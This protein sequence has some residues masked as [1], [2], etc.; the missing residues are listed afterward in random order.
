MGWEPTGTHDG[1][2]IAL[3]LT[4]QPAPGNPIF[5]ECNTGVEKRFR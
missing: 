3:M 2:A 5:Q 4:A 1:R